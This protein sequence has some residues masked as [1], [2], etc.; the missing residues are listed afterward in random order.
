[1]NSALD[2]LKLPMVPVLDGNFTLLNDIQ[3][4][5]AM[6]TRRSAVSS[7]VWAEGIVIRPL[8]EQRYDGER[9]SFKVINPEFL[10]KFGE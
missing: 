6:A 9:V 3:A 1:M 7:D 5:V 2:R 8:K 4:L 10:L